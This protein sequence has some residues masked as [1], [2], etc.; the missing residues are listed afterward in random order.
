VRRPPPVTLDGRSARWRS[1][2]DAAQDALVAAGRCDG[3]HFP[4]GELATRGSG[5]ARERTDTA[6]VLDEL[7]LEEHVHL[8]HRLSAPRATLRLLG[9]PRGTEALVLALD[10][11]LTASADLHAA[12]WAE[13]F[14][15]LLARRAGR[16][17]ERLAP[18]R[19]YDP[20]GDYREHLH[21]RPRLEGVRTFLASRGITL[22]E[23]TSGDAPGTET[24]HG[25]ANRKELLLH[26]RLARQG[27]AAFEGSRRYL[28]D[29]REAGLRIAVV[30]ASSNTDEILD[31]SGLAGLVDVRIDGDRMRERGL[32]PRPA[33][34]TF[35]AACELLRVEPAHAAGF[36]TS[37]A[38]IAGLRAAGMGTAIGVARDGIRAE[39]ADRVVL[40]LDQLLD[41][42][43]RG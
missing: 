6:R 30:S 33:P 18:S 28:E 34:D 37:S 41:P 9:L 35:V 20:R 15:E 42:V 22:P 40:D 25:L 16:P 32:R 23:G 1:A 27:V 36:V 7:A 10:G 19:P 5:L 13:T 31:R 14:E 17:G 29:A 38:G 26:R 21:G 11:V 2:F 43:L 3:L 4:Q 8:T 39:N 12:A 24:V